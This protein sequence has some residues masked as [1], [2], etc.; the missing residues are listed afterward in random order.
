MP[1][2]SEF[3]TVATKLHIPE[4]RSGLVER[5]ALMGALEAGRTRRATVVAAPTGFGKTSALAEWA[6]GIEGIF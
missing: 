1:A 4:R 6:G 5:P 3:V 2:G